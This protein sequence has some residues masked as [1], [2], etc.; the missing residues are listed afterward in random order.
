M[1]YPIHVL[2]YDEFEDLVT[3][4]CEK[5]LGIGVVKFGS[6]KDGGRDG[7]FNGK[8]QSFPSASLVWEGNILIQAKHTEFSDR[9]ITDN[10]FR[11]IVEKEIPKVKDLIVADKI[12]YYIVFTNRKNSA[13]AWSELRNKVI[14]ESGV[15]DC[16]FICNEKI[17]SLLDSNPE[18][19]SKFNLLYKAEISIDHNDFAQVITAFLREFSP[20]LRIQKTLADI[21]FKYTQLPDKNRLNN[22]TDQYYTG[23]IQESMIYFDDIKNFLEN[24]RNSGLQEEYDNTVKELQAQI[25]TRSNRAYPL[26]VI[27][28]NLYDTFLNR[29]PELKSMRKFVHCFIHYMYC[30]C[31]IGIKS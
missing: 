7:F 5:A 2:N 12:D 28:L 24:P 4:I 13:N 29:F 25:L 15:K 18:L 14:A 10:D 6:G 3:S 23:C 21:D 11:K 9:N 31:D 19:V 17:E 26:E 20:K 16:H 30:N 1:Y 22:I 8:A 27:F